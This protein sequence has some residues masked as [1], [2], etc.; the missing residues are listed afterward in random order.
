[1]KKELNKKTSAPEKVKELKP[2]TVLL[3]AFSISEMNEKL[4]ANPLNLADLLFEKLEETKVKSRIMLL[5]K[6]DEE[7][8]SDSISYYDKRGGITLGTMLRT[9][10]DDKVGHVPTRLMENQKFS[11]SE[12][13]NSK[14][15]ESVIYKS[16]YYFALNDKFL[17][18]NLASNIMITRFQAYINW[19]IKEPLFEFLHLVDE[20]PDLKLSDVKSISISDPQR[21]KRNENLIESKTL[22]LNHIKGIVRKI[23]TQ[24][25]GLN[26]IDI[27]KIID[28]R[29][30]LKFY[31]P[32]TMK[33]DE[34]NRLMGLCLKPVGDLTNVAFIQ[35]NNKRITADRLVKTKPVS[36]ER[37]KNDLI[38]EQ[39]LFDEMSKFI[40]E[41]T[42]DA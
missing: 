16:H 39:S 17:V 14:V 3:R 23:F 28:L 21:V 19:F 30:L 11:I 25:K 37:I 35:K 34:Y 1:M 32:K 13:K 4:S 26:D 20:I 42:I 5:N 18:T 27:E 36:V 29:L 2:K 31:K 24:T 22:S 38:S 9:T 41:L 40:K 10:G 33:K 12:I 6:D 7:K 15:K 8:T